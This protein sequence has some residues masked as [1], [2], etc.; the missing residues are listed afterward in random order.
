MN[1][2]RAGAALSYLNLLVGNLLNLLFTPLLLRSLGQAGYGL[3]SLV[4]AFVAYL[5]VLDFGLGNAV[6]RYV[7][8]F[9]AQGQPG[10]EAALLRLTLRIY[11][12]VAVAA[13]ALG[14]L[15]LPNLRA[16]FGATLS[17]AEL[18]EA[19]V[20]FAL[21]TVNLAVSFPLGA[22]QAVVTGHERFVFLRVT[23]LARILLRT[24]LL[25][26][27][28]LLGHKAIA[29]VVMDTC[30]NVATG[31]LNIGYV[32]LVLR[33]PAGEHRLDP[34]FLR[35][36]GGYSAF[37]FLNIIVDLLFWKI[38]HVVL[39]AMVG[40]ASVAVFAIAMQVAHYY[41]QFPLAVS[42]VFLPRI[43]GMVVSGATPDELLAIFARTARI[44]L[45]A[46][47][48]LLGGFALFGREFVNLWAGPAYDDAWRL[49]LLV[50]VPLTVPLAQTVGLYVLQAK[51]MHGFRSVLYLVVAVANVFASLFLVRRWG[52][53]GAAVGTAAT[54]VVGHVVGMNLY[55]HRR[56]RLDIPRFVR[57]VSA[58]IVP[59]AAAATAAGWLL[60]LVPGWSWPRLVF[61]GAVFTALYAGGM[62]WFGL[63]AYERGLAASALGWLRSFRAPRDAEP[64]AT[65]RPD[66]S[67]GTAPP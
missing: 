38:G 34:G 17:P 57:L 3:Y 31:L 12:A 45:I 29:I 51:N 35:E 40:T 13:L 56:I 24:A 11:G 36:L 58:G 10:A 37:V 53:L 26:S 66:A 16:L 44:Q 14:A 5:G 64:A 19:R 47:C 32:R 54:L 33:L 28:L 42:S 48:Y 55:Y 1:Q 21:M 27:L 52:A 30:L 60:T 22:F 2:I 8:K 6:V 25:V 49:A 23:V 61:R 41:R 62:A 43:T 46:L 7:A 9:R 15:L 67:A 63:N 50:M 18:S 20:L 4:G 59:A 65:G 39:G